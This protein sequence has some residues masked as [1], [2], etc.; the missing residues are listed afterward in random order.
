VQLDRDL[1]LF[2]EWFSA[3]MRPSYVSWKIL[4]RIV[5]RAVERMMELATGS[6]EAIRLLAAAEA[7]D[8]QPLSAVD[9]TNCRQY[10][11]MLSGKCLQQLQAAQPQI[12]RFGNT[13]NAWLGSLQ[14]EQKMHDGLT[15]WNASDRQLP[16]GWGNML[17]RVQGVLD[18]SLHRYVVDRCFHTP[19]GQPPTQEPAEGMLCL[20]HLLRLSTD[21]VGRLMRE[22]GIETCEL[23]QAAS[24]GSSRTVELQEL[25]DLIPS[26]AQRGGRLYRLLAVTPSQ[27]SDINGRLKQLDMHESCTIVPAPFGEVPVAVCDASGLNLPGLISAFWRPSSE[28][29]RLAER[30]HTRSDVA[31]PA[32]DSLLTPPIAEAAK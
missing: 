2:Q 15:S 3:H 8:H 10:I 9:L 18:S 4:Q 26:A 20:E 25:E 31:W 29:F 12:E 17:Q 23:A 30:L 27:S 32:I 19:A 14:A 28:T 13:L 24:S 11:Q 7:G 16:I 1:R 21:L 6:D 5:L 22:A